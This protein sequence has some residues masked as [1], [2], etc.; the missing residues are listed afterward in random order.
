MITAENKGLV[1]LEGPDGAGKTWLARQLIERYGA[2]YS[3]EGPPPPDVSA[4][5]HYSRI[6]EEWGSKSAV[7]LDRFALGERVY[8]PVLRQ[9]DSLGVEGWKLFQRLTRARGVRHIICIPRYETCWRAWKSNHEH[10]LIKDE[11]RHKRTYDAFLDLRH[12]V[13]DAFFY[14]WEQ[15]HAFE[16]LCEWLEDVRVT[17]PRDAIGSPLALT[18]F[19]GD[20]GNGAHEGRLD[21]PFFSTG[22]SSG[23]LNDA[24]ELAGF[25]E[26]CVALVN[27]RRYDGRNVNIREVMRELP[28]LMQVIALGIKATFACKCQH[29]ECRS[30]PHPQYWKRFYHHHMNDYVS[31]LKGE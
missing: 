27:S 12:Y 20:I 14:D 1:I 30:V 15:P 25:D 18:L 17:L 28:L 22:G 2:V 6:L 4:L 26:N 3:H 9:G 16:S 13:H 11:G 24:L 29:V 8:G 7:V 31:L 5:V 23:Y 10:E 21:L 19:V